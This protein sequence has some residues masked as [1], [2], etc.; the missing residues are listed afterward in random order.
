[1]SEVSY[2]EHVFSA[3]G[4][5]PDPQKVEAIQDWPTPTDV[6]ALDNFWV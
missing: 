4:M 5:T 1:M 2:T 3:L 6:K